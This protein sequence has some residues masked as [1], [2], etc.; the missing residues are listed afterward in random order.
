MPTSAQRSW[1]PTILTSRLDC[2]FC[3]L[4]AL[5][6]LRREVRHHQL[7]FTHWHISPLE[8]SVQPGHSGRDLLLNSKRRRL[9]LLLDPR[10]QAGGD[11]MKST[12]HRSLQTHMSRGRRI[13][14]LLRP[15]LAALARDRT[16]LVFSMSS[17]RGRTRFSAVHRR[18]RHTTSKDR[19]L[20]SRS[21]QA[22][23]HSPIS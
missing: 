20:R 13:V 17:R 2:S 12:H 9:G 3:G 15:C 4:A 23:L 22:R 5:T 11:S 1:I 7:M 10:L 16:S 8:Q 19:R 14:A 21:S 6:A 18:R